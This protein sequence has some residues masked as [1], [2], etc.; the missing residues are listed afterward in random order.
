LLRLRGKRCVQ[1]L[2]DFLVDA[3]LNPFTL[4]PR[5]DRQCVADQISER[6]ANPLAELGL[7]LPRVVFADVQF[8]LRVSGFLPAISRSRSET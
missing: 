6:L 7:D 3:T 5:L 2:L 1:E 8:L 4:E